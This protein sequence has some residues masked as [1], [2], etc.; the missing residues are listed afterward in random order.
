MFLGVGGCGSVRKRG[1]GYVRLGASL[2]CFP[3]GHSNTQQNS[4]LENIAGDSGL[5][6]GMTDEMKKSIPEGLVYARTT[7]TT[8]CSAEG[9]QSCIARS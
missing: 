6:G 5:A 7:R 3:R 2:S 8:D 9:I 4:K 1:C